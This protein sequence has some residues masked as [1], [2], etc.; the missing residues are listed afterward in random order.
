MDDKCYCCTPGTPGAALCTQCFKVWYDSD[1]TDAAVL[2]RETRWRRAEGFWPWSSHN[3]TVQ[4]LEAL[5]GL[6]LPDISAERHATLAQKGD[7]HE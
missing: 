4:E 2:A 7:S 5:Q 1:T 6:P 3:A